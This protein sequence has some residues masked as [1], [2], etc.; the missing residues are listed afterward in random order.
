MLGTD[1]AVAELVSSCSARK[2]VFSVVVLSGFSDET[3]P[4]FSWFVMSV[5]ILF[6]SCRHHDLAAQFLLEDLT[7]PGWFVVVWRTPMHAHTHTHAYM[8]KIHVKKLQMVNTM[9]THL[10]CVYVC[11]YMGVPSYPHHTSPSQTRS[12]GC[13]I[14]RNVI[15]LE[16]I[17]VI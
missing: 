7:P 15:R 5:Y 2:L 4:C 3:L 10:A 8:L 11:A 12:G 16:L 9:E 1:S 13:Q 14:T 6:L 17:K